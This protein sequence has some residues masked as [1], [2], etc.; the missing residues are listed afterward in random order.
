LSSRTWCTS[1]SR[2][3]SALSTGRGSECARG[4]STAAP[5]SAARD[6]VFRGDEA[7]ALREVAPCVSHE[8]ADGGVGAHRRGQRVCRI[9][10]RLLIARDEVGFLFVRLAQ[11]FDARAQRVASRARVS[12]FE[13]TL[14]RGD[15]ARLYHPFDR[16]VVARAQHR[17]VPARVDELD[18]RELRKHRGVALRVRVVRSHV[19]EDEDHEQECDGQR[20]GA[21]RRLAFPCNAGA[22]AQ[23]PQRV[24]PAPPPRGSFGRAGML[25]THRDRPCAPAD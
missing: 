8:R 25:F 22:A 12:G 6:E 2:R 3:A 21:R 1:L 14:Y 11:L 15:V 20:P 4:R 5:S 19:Q 10:A 16:S 18:A 9:R 7:L 17:D 24:P 13:R 23:A